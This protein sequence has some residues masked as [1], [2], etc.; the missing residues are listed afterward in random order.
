MTKCKIRLLIFLFSL[1]MPLQAL[2]S[3]SVKSGNPSPALSPDAPKYY[4][5][6]GDAFLAFENHE[7]Y[8]FRYFYLFDSE[9][10]SA[11]AKKGNKYYQLQIIKYD[12]A[13][14]NPIWDSG[15]TALTKI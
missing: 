10:I 2:A 4:F 13:W 15:K 3:V 7:A 5:I 1:A 12:G 9:T 11:L 14:S 6:L 8:Y